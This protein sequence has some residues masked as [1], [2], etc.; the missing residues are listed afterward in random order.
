MGDAAEDLFD[1]MM[2]VDS[3]DCG[4]TDQGHYTPTCKYCGSSA[5]L[6][7]ATDP[8]TGRWVLMSAAGTRHQCRPAARARVVAADFEDL[9]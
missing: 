4:Y 3:D 8:T 6:W 9:D 2:L 1:Q 7:W 5:G